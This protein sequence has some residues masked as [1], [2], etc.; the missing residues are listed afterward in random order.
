MK[1]CKKCGEGL[2][3]LTDNCPKCDS[4]EFIDGITLTLPDI[5]KDVTTI[6]SK[7]EVEEK[8]SEITISDNIKPKSALFAD[9]LIKARSITNKI[10]PQLSQQPLFTKNNENISPEIVNILRAIREDINTL[11]LK[12]E[13]AFERIFNE[14]KTKQGLNIA[15]IKSSSDSD[16]MVPVII[17]D[18]FKNM[19]FENKKLQILVI[20]TILLLLALIYSYT[21]GGL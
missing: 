8:I 13:G 5:E 20:I 4:N 19:I 12:Y 2:R 18:E 16:G 17:D 15:S 11:D 9:F 3:D 1:T 6:S 14:L 10:P 7:I 21:S